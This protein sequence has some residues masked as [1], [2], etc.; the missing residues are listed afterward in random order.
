MRSIIVAVSE[1][2]VI[3]KENGLPWKLSAD[4]KRLKALTMG[5]HILMGRKT[6]ESLGKP[7]PGRT[8]VVITTQKD[9]SAP[10]A[11]VVNS[12]EEALTVS[13]GDNEIFIFGGAEIFKKALPWV[14]KVY[15][16]R[17]HAK[18]D[19]DAFF[20]KLE[21]LE[22]KI[23][24]IHDYKADEKNEYDYSFITMERIRK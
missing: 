2:N 15:L 17:V 3:G 6:W 4:L 5:H 23:V 24:D 13:G 12:L 8:N 18:I 21:L 1:N 7:L 11:T 9:Y 19:G 22:W 14:N 10:G 20:P 16:T